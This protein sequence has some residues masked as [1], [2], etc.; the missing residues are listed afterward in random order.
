MRGRLRCDAGGRACQGRGLSRAPDQERTRL[1]RVVTAV[2][3]PS[4]SERASPHCSAA[5]LGGSWSDSGVTRLALVVLCSALLCSSVCRSTC[6]T[7][8]VRPC[9]THRGRR[10]SL[11]CVPVSLPSSNNNNNHHPLHPIPRLPA[12]PND[13]ATRRRLSLSATATSC[14]D[15]DCPAFLRNHNPHS[16]NLPSS[17]RSVATPASRHVSPVRGV[18]RT[19]SGEAVRR[20]PGTTVSLPPPGSSGR[21]PSPGRT[22]FRHS[23]RHGSAHEA[24][25]GAGLRPHRWRS[26]SMSGAPG[27][28]QEET[29]VCRQRPMQSSQRKSRRPSHSLLATTASAD[30]LPP[31][32]RDGATPV[33]AANPESRVYAFDDDDDDA[34]DDDIQDEAEFAGDNDEIKE[35]W[36]SPFE[37][38]PF[39]DPAEGTH[40][41]VPKHRRSDRQRL[42]NPAAA[43]ASTVLNTRRGRTTERGPQGAPAV[44]REPVRSTSLQPPSHRSRGGTTPLSSRHTDPH[45]RTSAAGVLSSLGIPL[46]EPKKEMLVSPQPRHKRSLSLTSNLALTP[47]PFKP[48]PRRDLS[49]KTSTRSVSAAEVGPP[50]ESLAPVRGNQAPPSPGSAAAAKGCPPT[51]SSHGSRHGPGLSSRSTLSTREGKSDRKEEAESLPHATRM[52]RNAEDDVPAPRSDSREETNAAR[53]SSL[54]P[55]TPSDL[56][57]VDPPR[58]VQQDGTAK[59]PSNQ[60]H[61]QRTRSPEKV[62]ARKLMEPARGKSRSF[63]KALSKTTESDG[64]PQDAPSTTT[65]SMSSSDKNNSPQPPRAKASSRSNRSRRASLG[66]DGKLHRH[67]RRNRDE[68]QKPFSSQ[69]SVFSSATRIRRRQTLSHAPSNEARSMGQTTPRASRRVS[70]CSSAGME[71]NVAAVVTTMSRMKER[72]SSTRVASDGPMMNW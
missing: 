63:H 51:A 49:N 53:D 16:G 8:E 40:S 29:A 72:S 67:M 9:A 17:A 44:A 21:P 41:A 33:A 71:G 31:V 10:A 25:P 70:L 13:V 5:I 46:T 32:A 1:S 11:A 59:P 24:R 52:A 58:P 54:D 12:K 42:R 66:E 14:S 26:A 3:S 27:R 2:S 65:A 36:P 7:M 62:T 28:S 30:S 48:L 69:Q 45:R 19:H 60:A 38:D 34:A 68:E 57:G 22:M 50:G 55:S 39:D 37:A 4:E 20:G 35:V 47:T 15:L 6:Q 61:R 43:A 56:V 23:L 18:R 64:R